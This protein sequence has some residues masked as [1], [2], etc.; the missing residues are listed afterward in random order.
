MKLSVATVF[1]TLSSVSAFAPSSMGV[2]S[3]TQLEARKPFI[4]GNWKLNPQ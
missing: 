3:A 2:R 1:A 4:S